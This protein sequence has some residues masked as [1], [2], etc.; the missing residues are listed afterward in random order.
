MD[1]CTCHELLGVE[2]KFK[3]A[4]FTLRLMFHKEKYNLLKQ[5]TVKFKIQY[6]DE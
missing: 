5:G 1:V 3:I 2:N 6:L 4:K